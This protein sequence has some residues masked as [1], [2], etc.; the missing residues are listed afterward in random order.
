[1]QK[2]WNTA[3]KPLKKY[4]LDMVHFMSIKQGDI[5]LLLVR[6]LNFCNNKNESYRNPYQKMAPKHMF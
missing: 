2:E 6:F 1:M 3:T 4:M 5:R